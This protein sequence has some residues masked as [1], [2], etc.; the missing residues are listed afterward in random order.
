MRHSALPAPGS[1]KDLMELVSRLLS[2]LLDRG[3]PLWEFHLIEGLENNRFAI[4]MKMHHASIDG[5]GGIEL[6]ETILK[7]QPEVNYVAPWTGLNKKPS[8]NPTTNLL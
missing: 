5:M 6:M 7:L 2:R 4:Y 1:E 3:R 8:R